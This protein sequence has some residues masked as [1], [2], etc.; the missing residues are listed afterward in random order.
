MV[1]LDPNPRAPLSRTVLAII[2]I[3][4]TA[5]PEKDLLAS[6]DYRMEV[7][8]PAATIWWTFW[9]SYLAATFDSYWH[10]RDVKVAR[11]EVND[12]LGQDLEAW[13]LTDPSNAIFKSGGSSNTAT[14]VMRL[15]FTSTV[16]RLTKQLGSD[17]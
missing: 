14:D 13:T 10:S 8:S 17:P 5:S 3:E 16:S 11:S 12:A 4:F 15:A 2:H 6:W 7:T 1:P 9:Q